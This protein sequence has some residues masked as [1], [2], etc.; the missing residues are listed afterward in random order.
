MLECRFKKIQAILSINE[1]DF[2]FQGFLSLKK[3][4]AMLFSLGNLYT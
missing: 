3:K 2:F 1:K 4:I